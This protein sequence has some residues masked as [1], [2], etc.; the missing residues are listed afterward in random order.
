MKAILVFEARWKQDIRLKG[1]RQQIDISVKEYKTFYNF[2]VNFENQHFDW[3]YKKR[4][5]QTF[6]NIVNDFICDF[7]IFANNGY[8][9]I[10]L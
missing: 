6:D 4:K 3:K 1:V 5:A 7:Q 2:I 10:L 8:K 9:K